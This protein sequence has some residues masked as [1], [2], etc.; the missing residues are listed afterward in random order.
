MQQLT[1]YIM[2]KQ[3][4]FFCYYVTVVGLTDEKVH[5]KGVRTLLSAESLHGTGGGGRGGIC[6]LKNFE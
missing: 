1:E 4:H 5:C 3:Q 6:L 2:D